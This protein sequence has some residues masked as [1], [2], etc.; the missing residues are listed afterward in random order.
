[1]KASRSSA[2]KPLT[3]MIA[4]F[5]RGLAY[6]DIPERIRDPLRQSI[7][8]TV[9]CALLG[10]TTPFSKLVTGYTG[11]WKSAGEA[12]VW[13]TTMKASAPFAAMSNSAACH[14]WDFDDTILP[15]IIH[16]GSVAV[17]TAFALAERSKAPARGKD[18]ITAMAAGYEVGNVIGT[19]LGG[20]KFAA[21][22]FYISV[23]A[24]FVALA[25]AG[26][27]MKLTEEQ[28][29]RALGLAASQ[30]AGLYSA[31]LAKRFNSPKAVLGG[32]FAADL[33]KRGL[34]ASSDAIEAGY[35]GFLGTFSRSPDNPAFQ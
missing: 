20:K 33:A 21:D 14:A 15:S 16:P 18:L 13:G 25:T 7:T 6:S 26:K 9:G 22:G 10:S 17:P 2:P 11:E 8:D 3:S 5:I 23:P 34:E 27:L 35:S 30:A 31:T 1:M 4:R 12:A 28:L 24:I 32:I 19:A 29:T